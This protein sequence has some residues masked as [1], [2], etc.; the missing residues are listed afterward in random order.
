MPD[1][2]MECVGGDG[3]C[4]RRSSILLRKVA[5]SSLIGA[6]TFNRLDLLRCPSQD[7]VR[8]DVLPVSETT[9]SCSLTAYVLGRVGNLMLP[10]NGER[11]ETSK[12]ALWPSRL[13]TRLVLVTSTTSN[14]LSR[15][16][17][18][19]ICDR[20]FVV[21]STRMILSNVMTS[22]LACRAQMSKQSS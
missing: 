14:T 6:E 22:P 5:S 4:S 8:L 11:L 16:H 10:L 17:P 9:R 7:P 18:Q 21:R 20:S 12:S 1:H 19:I 15:R 13:H 3:N 2:K